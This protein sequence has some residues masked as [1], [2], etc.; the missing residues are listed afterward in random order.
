[1]NPRL[2]LVVSGS[3]VAG[4][5]LAI[6][7]DSAIKGSALL[8]A[9]AL[10][11][12]ALLRAPASARH[13]VW[14]AALVGALVLP[15]AASSLPGWRALPAWVAWEPSARPA[16]PA[17]RAATAPIASPDLA[18]ATTA[19]P[20]DSPTG[21]PPQPAPM[22]APRALA[23]HHV[24]IV[25]GTGF[26]LALSPLA[27]GSVSL[28]RHRRTRTA[29]EGPL[30]DETDAVAT[31][32][33]LRRPVVIHLGAPD[34]M[35][36]VW[37]LWRHRLLLPSSASGWH[38]AQ[39]R[40]VLLH[41]LAHLRRRDP[42]T[43]LVARLAAAVHW[44]NPLA[45]VALRALRAEQERACDD[46]VLRHGIVPST[47]A[48]QLLAIATD[49]RSPWRETATALAM[50]RP[51]R[52]AERIRSVLDGRRDR[53]ALARWSGALA[54]AIIAVVTIPLAMLRAADHPSPG[55]P[56][57]LPK[58]L[59]GLDLTTFPHTTKPSDVPIFQPVPD[60]P[61]TFTEADGLLTL[62]LGD[63]GRAWVRALLGR[64]IYF[65][66]IRDLEDTDHYFGPIP[67]NPFAAL[68]I[69][70]EMVAALESDPGSGNALNT[71]RRLLKNPSPLAES[72][73][74]DLIGHLP[75]PRWLHQY[76]EILQLSGGRPEGSPMAL[77]HRRIASL[78]DALESTRVAVAD[79]EY[80][81]PPPSDADD[82]T[83][84]WGAADRGLRLGYS[85]AV[86]GRTWRHGDRVELSLWVKCEGDSGV[87]I[88]TTPRADDGAPRIALAGAD[89][90][91]Y[92]CE[93]VQFS[94]WLVST[95]YR[96]APGEKM[97]VKKLNFEIRDPE[98]AQT[99]SPTRPTGTLSAPPGRYS[100]EV[101]LTL[102]GFEKKNDAGAIVVPGA[103]EWTGTLAAPRREVTI[104]TGIA[105]NASPSFGPP[106]ADGLR[107]AWVFEP[108]RRSY[109]I[110]EVLGCRILFHNSGDSPVEFQTASWH[111]D[112]RWHV[113]DAAGNEIATAGASYSGITPLEDLVL[114]PGE[115]HE[116]GAHG[117]AIGEADYDEAYSLGKIGKEIHAKPGDS[118]TIRWDVHYRP[119][120]RKQETML[121]TGPVTF[122]VVARTPDAPVL[123]GVARGPGR[124]DLA[125]GVKLQVTRTTGGGRPAPENS[126]TL[127]WLDD[128]GE[129]AGASHPLAL[130]PGMH[131]FAIAWQRGG[132]TL[133]VAEE[134]GIRQIGFADP[135]SVTERRIP[136]ADLP[137]RIREAIATDWPAGSQIDG[138]TA[139]WEIQVVDGL[140]GAS[141]AG[142]DV[143]ISPVLPAT[144]ALS[145]IRLTC[146]GEGRGSF[147][148]PQGSGATLAIR[149]DGV[150]ATTING[151]E[152]GKRGYPPAGDPWVAADPEAP[153]VVEAWRGVR[154]RGQ[155]VDPT[156][157][158][159]ADATVPIGVYVSS[160]EWKGRLGM[161]PAF[162]S[163]DHGDWP[164]WLTRAKTDAGGNFAAAVPPAGARGWIRVSTPVVPE[165][166]GSAAGFVPF[167]QDFEAPTEDLG[168][169]RLAT[170]VTV[171][172][173]V[174]DALGQPL[175]GVR[176]M[177]SGPR[178][179]Y[180]G[181]HTVSE[182]SGS[183][184]FLPMAPGEY[185]M[186]AD[187]RLRDTAGD[188]V[189][190]DVA[191]VVLP[192]TV[193]VPPTSETVEV[194]VQAVAHRRLEFAWRDLRDPPGDRVSFYNE[195]N[196]VGEVPRADG[197]PL[198]WRG[199][200]EMGTRPDG[201]STAFLKVPAELQ[202]A[203]LH[204]PSDGIVTARYEDGHGLRGP[205]QIE[206]GDLADGQLGT[207]VGYPPEP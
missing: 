196:V 45:W 93:F 143:T 157:H 146:D 96:L 176:L 183:F 17:D 74:L 89:G 119:N 193:R 179:P 124:F 21:L 109:A 98:G 86:D 11:V 16:L 102:P 88:S 188:V 48:S 81:A 160:L 10:V 126:A 25:W 9:A 100:L 164:N 180:D 84:A 123:P 130:P 117:M 142:A 144:G 178:G 159:L 13:L 201:T 173:R 174:L 167:E 71:L 165:P 46:T 120:G 72:V 134:G 57:G 166:T 140:T 73:A 8:S 187:A 156:G 190:R 197:S 177:M 148:L 137:E 203:S 42:L 34:A 55:F 56:P 181:R 70:E 171:T 151:L 28:R 200:T 131:A 18:P 184:A 59:R 172:G 12:V 78:Q 161:D 129:S 110:G 139:D 69:R 168:T 64:E 65:L 186:S 128:D 80:G 22:A 54:L 116:V 47:Y 87:K 138:A 199:D 51:H 31:E 154:V 7:I 20:A 132:E 62:R 149:D 198:H 204:L 191:A 170:G 68:G 67:G 108:Q 175:P 26:A 111:Q 141:I 36:M 61:G 194:T 94:A 118:V 115:T 75:Q 158:P 49:H 206:L 38:P 33:G 53:R 1:M 41:E 195:F 207:I 114:A 19:A 63:G 189:S 14:F 85:P 39:L 6:V 99:D 133:W 82:D 162:Y 15:F 106:D 113:T 60:T 90:S 105:A 125:A 50:A 24:L 107:A 4:A 145:P 58:S 112:D 29:D 66:Q 95:R 202:N 30:R 163:W 135:G 27:V 147:T 32:L 185:T 5:A 52:I 23:A 79:E 83:I 155:L 3:A 122:G 37:G 150:F 192:Q 44:F 121:A 104:T 182:T 205:G 77:A 136:E 40:G 91:T 152:G 76:D 169:L 35:P 43:M 153:L 92:P 101:A 127:L 2:Y 103:G 97:R